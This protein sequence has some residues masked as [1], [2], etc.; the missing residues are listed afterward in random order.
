MRFNRVQEVTS[1]LA[2][3]LTLW[4]VV[5]TSR[6]QKSLETGSFTVKSDCVTPAIEAKIAVQNYQITSPAGWTFLD[7]GLPVPAIVAGTEMSGTVNGV[8]RVCAQTFGDSNSN[9]FIISCW[10][11]TGYVCN[12]HFR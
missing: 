10:D 2:L 5:A 4:A 9:D 1:L 8:H 7:L 11:D 3:I 6:I 12:I